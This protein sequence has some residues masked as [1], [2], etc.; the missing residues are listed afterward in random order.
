MQDGGTLRG[1]GDIRGILRAIFESILGRSCFV[2]LSYHLKHSLGE[3]PL[4]VFLRGPRE[5]YQ[6]LSKFFGENGATVTFKI[7]CGR[8]IALSGFEELTPDDI[9]D[10]LLRDEEAARRVI[11]EMLEKLASK[12]GGLEG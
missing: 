6:A 1:A 3:D 4:T 8:L 10:L 12:G 2:A 9:Y 7:V 5:F 11:V